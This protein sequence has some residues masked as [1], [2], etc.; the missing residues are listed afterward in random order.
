MTA[1]PAWLAAW[2][3]GSWDEVSDKGNNAKHRDW[4]ASL[5]PS[6]RELFLRFPPGTVVELR[7]GAIP[8]ALDGDS[9]PWST[10]FGIVVGYV[11][12]TPGLVEHIPKEGAL[13]LLESPTPGAP[14]G[15]VFS[16]EVL[17]SLGYLHGYGPAEA[18]SNV[19]GGA[20]VAHI[21]ETIAGTNGGDPEEAPPLFVG[22][23]TETRVSVDRGEEGRNKDRDALVRFVAACLQDD[24][25]KLI[26]GG[27]ANREEVVR[28]LAE[29][30]AELSPLPAFDVETSAGED[31][32]VLVHIRPRG[33]S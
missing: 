4:F 12:P 19:L 7:R 24:M 17:S 8:R 2:T 29:T 27:K 32:S 11:D 33:A 10:A 13:F 16:P 1:P 15:V 18:A 26:S 14:Q 20:F 5:P 30:L 31:G 28:T 23:P 6:T 25:T 21:P 9:A 22:A 3:A